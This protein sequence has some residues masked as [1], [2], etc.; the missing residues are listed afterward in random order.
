MAF[1]SPTRKL[2][3]A[4]QY[5]V[6]RLLPF[7]LVFVCYEA[8]EV[9]IVA[10]ATCCWVGENLA[11][12]ARLSG[13]L[14]AECLATFLFL[15][16]PY[17]LY[18]LAVP[19]RFHGGK[20][21]RA[22]TTAFFLIFCTINALE[23]AAEIAGNES[24]SFYSMQFFRDP[25]ALWSE[26]GRSAPILPALL[27][28]AAA[29]GASFV[30]FRP[31]FR[32]ALPPTP[33][34][35]T[36]SAAPLIALGAAFLASM[37]SIDPASACTAER[38]LA[39]EGLFTF[40]GDL[41]AFTPVPNLAAIF[42]T[43]SLI[44]AALALGIL[45]LRPVFHRFCPAGPGALFAAAWKRLP[46]LRHRP[47]PSRFGVFL[48]V[49]LAAILLLRLV[50]MGAYPLM[51]TTEARYGEMAR[52]MLETGNW[53][54]PQF[55]YG[56]PFWGKP[57]LSFWASALT[58]S[59]AGIGAWGA[60]LA[61]FL[62]SVATGLLF[63]AWPW[64]GNRRR[65]RCKALACW[66]VASISGIGFV[67]SGAVM[68]DAFLTFG[69]ALSMVSFRRAIDFPGTCIIWK[70]L[71]FAGI[72]VGLLSKGPLA[73]VLTG[74]PVFLWALYTRRWRDMG[75]RLPWLAGTALVLAIC[76]PWYLMAE[77]ATP[78]FL[79]YFLMGEHFHRFVDRGW[80]GDLYG[81]GHA[82]AIGTIWLY[83]ITMFLPWSLL[84]PFL[85][86][87]RG[88]NPGHGVPR[89][90]GHE[91][92]STAYLVCWAL[93]PMLFFTFARNILPAYVLPSL[94]ALAIL[95]V[96][97]L[98]RVEQ[99]YPGARNFVF[100]PAPLVAV[101]AFFLWG[102]G[103]EHLE[104]RCQRELLRH[105]DTTSP[106]YY[107]DKERVPYS[108]Q[109]YSQGRAQ[110]GLPAPGT[111]RVYVAV[112]QKDYRAQPGRWEGWHAAATARGWILLVSPKP[113]TKQGEK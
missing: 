24:F 52:K 55:D 33:D 43:P 30:L 92:N 77:R 13:N 83:G 73:L 108:A 18:L 84:W 66:I 104:Y 28:V 90:R 62:A 10:G 35:L 96:E 100:L 6:Q 42:H 101:M 85:L 12:L 60:R 53:L 110:H 63:F 112:T 99:R 113:T 72:A 78:G 31:W 86:W 89:P 34:A 26:L 5:Y 67:A 65:K 22:L 2:P 38:E 74:L 57:P 107:A 11:D 76:L 50:S 88:R 8:I 68:T 70:Y 59:V 7:F 16:V 27:G 41:F 91:G 40:F 29:V 4:G 61:P 105:W 39:E 19:A 23:E 14:V 9:G 44:A 102:G 97:L 80:Q 82:R 49:L 109:F 64:H 20:T 93:S 58:M 36:R 54:T 17:L 25:G 95:T 75:Q 103:F 32:R 79:N 111:G 15:I 48:L 47:V 37:G 69:L 56:V 81:S 45:A 87:K 3:A 1:S 51:D 21:D 98:W 106:L 46:A 94:P 71:F